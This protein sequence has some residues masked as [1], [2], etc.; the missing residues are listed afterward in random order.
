MMSDRGRC[1]IAYGVETRIG[2]QARERNNN[3]EKIRKQIRR[4]VG[5]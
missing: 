5:K 4:Y 3:M 1:G 2:E